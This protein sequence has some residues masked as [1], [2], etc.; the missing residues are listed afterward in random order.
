LGCRKRIQIL[1]QGF[2]FKSNG[3]KHFQTN[4]GLDFKTG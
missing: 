4:F 2:W 3:F 1:I